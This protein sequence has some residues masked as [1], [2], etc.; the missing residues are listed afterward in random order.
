MVTTAHLHW[1]SDGRNE[2]LEWRWSGDVPADA[3][4]RVGAI[5]HVVPPADPGSALG[6]RVELRDAAGSLVDTFRDQAPVRT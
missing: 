2:H 3:C 1:R 5:R 6:V 4:V